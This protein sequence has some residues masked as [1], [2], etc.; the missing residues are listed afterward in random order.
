[1]IEIHHTAVA[2]A[3]LAACFAY[4][5]DYTHVPS[6]LFG[7]TQFDPVGEPV[8]GLGAVYNAAMRVGPKTLGSVVEITAW[9]ENALIQLDSIDGLTTHSQWRFEA[10]SEEATR[11]TVDF[12]YELPGGLAGKALA[13]IVEPFVAQAIRHTDATLRR[14]VEQAAQRSF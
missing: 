10:V 12:H 2:Q 9:E 5:D 7:I 8:R 6:W 13:R 11:L 3:P 4:L 1:M 14:Q